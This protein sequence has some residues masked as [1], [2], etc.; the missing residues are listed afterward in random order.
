MTTEHLDVDNLPVLCY[1][2]VYKVSKLRQELQEGIHD[3]VESPLQVMIDNHQT[4]QDEEL[5]LIAESREVVEPRQSANL[6]SL[7][8]LV[9]QIDY[10]MRFVMNPPMTGRITID[11]RTRA[12][13]EKFYKFTLKK[14]AR[15]IK[16]YI[17]SLIQIDGYPPHIFGDY[18]RL[19]KLVQDTDDEIAEEYLLKLLNIV[20]QMIPPN[21]QTNHTF[22]VDS[23]AVDPNKVEG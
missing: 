18:V 3:Q 13:I 5:Q 7:Y 16:I 10:E 20:R 2:E 21:L 8:H 1:E 23:N 4:T 6:E 9:E 17:D 14:F 22:V 11:Y 19:T 15:M 12:R